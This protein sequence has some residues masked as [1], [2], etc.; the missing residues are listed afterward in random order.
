MLKLSKMTIRSKLVG[1]LLVFG[2]MPAIAMF[3]VYYLAMPTFEAA[4]REP[5]RG[6]AVSMIDVVER[7]L[8]ERYGDVQ[9]FG[10][11]AAAKDPANWRTTRDDNDLTRAM[12]G[13]MTN[14]GLYRLMMLVSPRGEVLAV[15]TVDAK[16]KP[17]DTSALRAARFAEA[18]WLRAAI[19]GNFLE[20][21]NGLTGT[22]VEGPAR[23]PQVAALYRDDGL[24][25][26]FAAPLKDERGEL[27]AVWVNFADFALVEQVVF[28]TFGRLAADGR[29]GAEITLLDREGRVLVDFDPVKFTPQSYRRDPA[30]I[31]T[32]NLAEAGVT[33]AVEAV[34]GK[35]GESGTMDSLHGRKQIV[36]AVG[37]AKSAGAY[38]YPGLGWSALVRVPT[39]EA[40]A[41]VRLV[42]REMELVLLLAAL[43]T[44]AAGLVIGALSARPIQRMTE[45]MRRLAGNDLS[46]EIPSLD[47]G[48]EIGA[49]GKAVQVFK[50][51]MAESGRL[52]AAQE[53]EQRRELDRARAVEARIVQ[54]EKA[55]ADVVGAVASA[56]GE[57][58]TT[59][60]SMA[61]AME[62][63]RSRTTLAGSASEEAANS[64]Q[65]VA[66]TTS[67]LS[68][69][70][71]EISQQV[72]HST[73]LIK[74]AVQQADSSNRQVQGLSQ[75]AQK[76]GEVVKIIADIAGQTNLLALNATIEAARAGEAGRGFAVV[77]SEV[78]AL[79]TQTA[80]AT[81]EIGAQ[82]G[83]IQE[84]TQ[85]SAHAIGGI[86][87][88]IGQ[89]DQ[90]A[91]AIV[92]AVEEQSA[93]TKEISRSVEAAARATSEVSVN[94]A[95][96]GEVA[97]QTAQ[98]V[99]RVLTLAS[100][101]QSRGEALKR[102]VDD[103]LAGVRAA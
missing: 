6:T 94:V 24:V 92:A 49:M 26:T 21:T 34:R 36:Q 4:F 42:E 28:A 70:I 81:E 43:A 100:D 71:G 79:A 75:A 93:A 47:R 45:A 15:N 33:A 19:A 51:S 86:A 50:D 102:Q 83:S 10:L 85:S 77:A 65:A 78:K 87:K 64:A 98:V 74:E 30:V 57:L 39:D 68:S 8:F 3:A 73:Q 44:L 84:A 35:P 60:E 23:S 58:R 66:S 52:R 96:V 69:A 63:T 38:D 61:E 5:I 22:V 25:L 82:I 95:G 16:G 40:Y 41:S 101:L 62:Q 91:S 7:N 97:D 13:Y 53:A 20:G 18:S 59:A 31:G 46:V 11:N 90:A 72:S 12:N 27:V 99:A 29:A 2:S 54:F 80:R 88:T 76:I 55:V 37:F 103:F 67:E 89:V 14:Y 32:L 48:D 1:V 56:S 17:L 9:A